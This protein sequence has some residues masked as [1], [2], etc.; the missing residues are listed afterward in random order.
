MRIRRGELML[1]LSIGKFRRDK[2]YT[3]LVGQEM[4][5]G[6][7]ASFDRRSGLALVCRRCYAS[8]S[9]PS[10]DLFQLF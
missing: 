6:L 1:S 10:F 7:E 2:Y 5:S 9:I 4:L 8:R 3:Q